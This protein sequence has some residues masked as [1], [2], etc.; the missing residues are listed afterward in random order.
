MISAVAFALAGCAGTQPLAHSSLRSSTPLR[1]G[2]AEEEREAL[3]QYVDARFGDRLN[4]RFS[5]VTHPG[6]WNAKPTLGKPGISKAG[7]EK[8]LE[9]PIA[10]LD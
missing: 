8:S 5:L 4:A 1:P 10:R 9:D 6:A 3:A 2:V 7:V